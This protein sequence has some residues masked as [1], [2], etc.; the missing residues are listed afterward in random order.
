ML[1]KN[2]IAD[3]E[4]RNRILHIIFNFFLIKSDSYN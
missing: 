4:F 2:C 3:V 1:M